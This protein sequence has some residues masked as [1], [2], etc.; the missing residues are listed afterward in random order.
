MA[1]KKPLRIE[2]IT[3]PEKGSHARERRVYSREVAQIVCLQP[4]CKFRGREAQQGICFTASPEIVERWEAFERAERSMAE[5]RRAIR[6]QFKGKPIKE[7]IAHLEAHADS[8]S[9]NWTLIL[10]ELIFL[11]RKL[12]LVTAKKPARKRGTP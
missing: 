4:R 3:K 8:A 12:A 1:D 2:K 10:D 11:R 7:Y 9:M 6:R 5:E